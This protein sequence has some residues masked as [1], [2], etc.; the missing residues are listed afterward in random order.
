MCEI[1]RT[2]WRDIAYRSLWRVDACHCGMVSVQPVVPSPLIAVIPGFLGFALNT[3]VA[4]SM[5]RAGVG[6]LHHLITLTRVNYF[7]T[8]VLFF[9]IWWVLG[10]P[11]DSMRLLF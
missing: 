8:A 3:L 5:K 2:P 4:F 9:V 10:T 7:L 6:E 11:D 1:L